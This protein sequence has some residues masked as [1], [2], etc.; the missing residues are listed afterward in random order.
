LDSSDDEATILPQRVRLPN[1]QSATVSPAVAPAVN[2]METSPI[3]Q[4]PLPMNLWGN[5]TVETATSQFYMMCGVIG[6]RETIQ[7]NRMSYLE[8]EIVNLFSPNGPFC[9]FNPVAA[10]TL[11]TKLGRVETKYKEL[12]RNHSSDP[13]GV[14][15]EDAPLWFNAVHAFYQW[16]E[17]NVGN[18]RA[19]ANRANLRV[20]QQNLGVVQLPLGPGAPAL[21]SEIAAENPPQLAGPQEIGAGI[22]IN[23]IVDIQEPDF[24]AEN[25]PNQRPRR[26]RNR[27]TQGNTVRRTNRQRTADAPTIQDQL[28]QGRQSMN[29]LAESMNQMVQQNAIPQ[30]LNYALNQLQGLSTLT[31]NL[32]AATGNQLPSP[33]RRRLVAAN[34]EIMS[35]FER[36]NQD[37]GSEE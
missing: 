32:L 31:N 25:L 23:D 36:N 8:S 34:M 10:R 20:V 12:V 17:S 29:N 5:P 9:G 6:Y 24:P 15:G 4:V 18:A 13:T 1:R 7:R 3:P 26:R 21:R 37:T 16:K 11:L 14:L 22:E 35:Q 27:V 19:Q 2:P 33:I 30:Q 28:A